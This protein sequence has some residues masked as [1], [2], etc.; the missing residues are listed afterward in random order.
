MGTKGYQCP[1][2]VNKVSFDGESADIFA[3]GVMLFCMVFGKRPFNTAH[4]K[5]NYY[6]AI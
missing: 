1:E 2:I 4:S 6:R 3:L 5:D